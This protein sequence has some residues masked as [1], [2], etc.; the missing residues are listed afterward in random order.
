MK[1]DFSTYIL[2]KLNEADEKKKKEPNI[3]INKDGNKKVVISSDTTEKELANFFKKHIDDIEI[4][5]EGDKKVYVFNGEQGEYTFENKPNLPFDKIYKKALEDSKDGDNKLKSLDKD[6][7]ELLGKTIAYRSALTVWNIINNSGDDFKQAA[8]DVFKDNSEYSIKQLENLDSLLDYSAAVGVVKDKKNRLDK[9]DAN[10]ET[11]LKKCNDAEAKLTTKE[12][13]TTIQQ[14]KKDYEKEF[15]DKRDVYEKAFNDGMAEQKKDMQ[16]KDYKWKDPATGQPPKGKLAKSNQAADAI[17]KSIQSGV[18][19]ADEFAKKQQGLDKAILSLAVMGVKGMMFGGKM[20][21]K[22]LTGFLKK[23]NLKDIMRYT[24]KFNDVKGKI[25]VF[26][27][28]YDE[29]KKYNDAQQQKKE[30]TDE[31]KKEEEDRKKTIS[32]KLSELMNTHVIPYY[33]CKMAI[34]VACFENI[35][36]KYI[37]RQEN[38][39][40]ST[41]NSGSGRLTIIEDNAILMERILE[42]VNDLLVKKGVFETLKDESSADAFKGI[43]KDLKYKKEYAD[44]LLKWKDK[45]KSVSTV[46]KFN[47]DNLKNILKVYNEKVIVNS[48]A[49]YEEFAKYVP[50]AQGLVKLHDIPVAKEIVIKFDGDEDAGIPGIVTGAKKENKQEENKDNGVDKEQINKDYKEISAALDELKNVNELNKVNDKFDTINSKVND[51]IDQLKGVVKNDKESDEA[52]K[53]K[54]EELLMAKTTIDKVIAIKAVMNNYNL[55]ESVA[56][57][58]IIKLL[59]EDEDE[60]AEAKTPDVGSIKNEISEII[61]GDITIDNASSFTEKS[62]KVYNEIDALYKAQNDDTKKKLEEYKDKPLQLLYAIGSINGEKKD[63]APVDVNQTQDAINKTKQ[64]IETAEN[65]DI[66]FN[67]EYYNEL[68]GELKGVYSTIEEMTK[69]NDE[70]L[71]A[72]LDIK[73]DDEIKDEL[74]PNLWHYKC[75]LT[76]ISQKKG[77]EKKELKDSYNPFYAHDMLVL[78]EA[79]TEENKDNNNVVEALKAKTK[80]IKE[81]LAKQDVAEF[82]KAYKVWKDEINQLLEKFD[83]IENKDKLTDPLQKLSAMG[84]Y[85]KNKPD[86]KKEEN[87]QPAEEGAKSEESEKSAENQKS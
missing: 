23:T 31:E 21:K 62:N 26:K 55:T 72:F 37:I 6:G 39:K 65:T 64:A 86:E 85:I 50:E 15:K 75:F 12:N 74:L 53:K 17:F 83:K 48:F 67:D 16:A 82:N 1:Y 80:T 30:K 69:N 61:G 79:E 22:L 42:V 71:Q 27:K 54:L 18:E 2:D 24:A 77:E 51:T 38:N 9:N 63:Q 59:N 3:T 7:F 68:K 19:K 35:E 47:K 8:L 5:D 11:L 25:K 66:I 76:I 14:I 20:L 33:Y 58:E 41:Y 28:E 52:K 36:G 81:I 56:M 46:S 49:S 45:I 78:L 29:W 34:I 73:I 44:N 60:N 87:P 84:N 13:Y 32:M 43:P 70:L 10:Y 57:N 40:W 4:K